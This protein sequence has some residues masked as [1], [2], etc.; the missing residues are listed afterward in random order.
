MVVSGGG[1]DS[2]GNRILHLV[3]LWVEELTITALC[4]IRDAGEQ[5]VLADGI[6]KSIPEFV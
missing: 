4:S 2:R 3:G 5:L 6:G 1:F